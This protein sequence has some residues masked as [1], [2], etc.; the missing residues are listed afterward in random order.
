MVLRSTLRGG[1]SLLTQKVPSLWIWVNLDPSD[2]MTFLHIQHFSVSAVNGRL[3]G[4][5]LAN[6]AANGVVYRVVVAG[7]NQYMTQCCRLSP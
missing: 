3:S 6:P 7:I 1:L 5:Y 2:H 4:V